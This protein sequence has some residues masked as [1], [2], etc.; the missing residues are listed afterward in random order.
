MPPFFNI[1]V[2][3]ALVVLFILVIYM[4]I[5]YKPKT[6]SGIFQIEEG[7]FVIKPGTKVFIKDTNSMLTFDDKGSIILVNTD[8]NEPRW[9]L[10]I[11]GTAYN[12]KVFIDKT[13]R[14]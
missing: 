10:D 1:I 7:D 8:N 4:F 11:T 5:A 13:S 12:N 2:T 6:A 3:I 14:T 9:Q